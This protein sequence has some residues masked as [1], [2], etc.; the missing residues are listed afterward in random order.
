MHMIN[1]IVLN[2]RLP[3][4]QRTRIRID[5]ILLRKRCSILKLVTVL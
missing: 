2:V 5:S 3:S 1:V 4:G